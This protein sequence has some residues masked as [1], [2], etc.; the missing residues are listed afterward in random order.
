METPESSGSGSASSSQ[1][2][3]TTKASSTLSIGNKMSAFVHRNRAT[4]V[5]S[6][7]IRGQCP[8]CRDKRQD[9][10]G[11]KLNSEALLQLAQA[12]RGKKA[13]LGQKISGPLDYTLEITFEDA[14]SWLARIPKPW[15]SSHVNE[16]MYSQV[17]AW[18]YLRKNTRIPVPVVHHFAYDND[19]GND[20]GVS[21]MLIEKLP[22]QAVPELDEED[23]SNVE[24]ARRF[25]DQLSDIIL[26]L[27]SCSF[28]KIGSIQQSP[29]D[30][31]DFAIGPLYSI[32]NTYPLARGRVATNRGP[33][34]SVFEY[35]TAFGELNFKDTKAHHRPSQPDLCAPV[36]EELARFF[37]INKMIPKFSIET[38][39]NGGPFVFQNWGLSTQN[40][41]VDENCN[42]T[43]ILGI[44]G[45]IGPLTSLC[46][47]PDLI[48]ETKRRGP[49]YDRKIFLNSFLNRD[50]PEYLS[51]VGGS[52]SRT[53]PI[54]DKEVRRALLRSAHKVWQFE[55][56]ILDPS[57]KHLHLRGR[58]GL[59]EYVF[60]DSKFSEK[61]AFK[62][63]GDQDPD[64]QRM[65]PKA[66]MKG[67]EYSW[68]LP[69]DKNKKRRRSSAAVNTKAK[70]RHIWDK[71][72]WVKSRK[73]EVYV[74]E[75]V[76]VH[77]HL[78]PEVK[79]YDG[80]RRS[81]GPEKAFHMAWAF[82]RCRDASYMRRKNQKQRK[83]V[84]LAGGRN[85]SSSVRQTGKRVRGW[86]LG[87]GGDSIR[88]KGKG[89][90]PVPMPKIKMDT[91]MSTPKGWKNLFTF[92]LLNSSKKA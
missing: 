59:Y 82:V 11:L 41:L 87:S 4:S 48:Y 52:G 27:S 45:T 34:I 73:E 15:R 91:T 22:G 32:N 5:S 81:N 38:G 83:V 58:G 31:D 84:R 80:K 89:K 74:R 64:F 70:A 90:A 67:G 46:K 14:V 16:S 19:P 40:V 24:K 20:V 10:M 9:D 29:M 88:N 1:F 42:I 39:F 44:G 77:K 7:S 33:F 68:D 25:H 8:E 17:S 3:R 85:R 53:S 69:E 6:T 43:G 76:R 13:T 63:L 36:D 51:T 18:R 55:N 56:S 86:S 54:E 78:P 61:S 47:Y 37:L 75:Y 35:L 23:P 92:T 28:D 66:E 62:S 30:P 57:H 21:F 71:A 12:L 65:V 26:E 60:E 79:A 50:V 72:P 49:L 2:S